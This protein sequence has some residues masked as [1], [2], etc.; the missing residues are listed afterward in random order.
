MAQME[1]S[2]RTT[3]AADHTLTRQNGYAV[4]TFRQL[5]G[6]S[7]DDLAKKIGVTAPHLRNLENEHRSARPEHLAA[8]ALALDVPELALKRMPD[9]MR[10]QVP[11]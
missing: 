7:V 5:R 11:A 3:A 9:A 4:R 1:Q 6:L 8:I 10:E 2:P